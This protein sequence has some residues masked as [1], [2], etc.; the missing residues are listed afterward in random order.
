MK[1]LP[2]KMT[3]TQKQHGTR[4]TT[5]LL[6]GGAVDKL[7]MLK[8]PNVFKPSRNRLDPPPLDL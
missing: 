2:G 1:K 7:S 8:T 4:K 6:S 3:N 5:P